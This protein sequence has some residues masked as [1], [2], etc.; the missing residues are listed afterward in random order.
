VTETAKKRRRLSPEARAKLAQNLVKARGARAARAKA[1]KKPTK[2]AR[3]RSGCPRSII[4]E[5]RRRRSLA[6]HLIERDI[7]KLTDSMGIEANLQRYLADRD[8]PTGYASFDYCCNYFRR[9]FEWDCVADLA[10]TDG[11]QLS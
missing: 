7:E 11:L 2:K 10:G 3:K 6:T 5:S 1:A 8:D 4:R 9:H